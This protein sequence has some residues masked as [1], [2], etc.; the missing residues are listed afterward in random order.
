[1]IV[2][3]LAEKIALE[4]VARDGT[5][6]VLQLH[7]LA[8]RAY[9]DGHI[10]AAG[11]LL[12][13]ADAADRALTSAAYIHTHIYPEAPVFTPD[14]RRFVY[15]RFRSVDQPREYW[16]CDLGAAEMGA[17]GLRPLTTPEEEPSVHG[18][19]V[20]PDGQWFVYVAVPEPAERET[21]S[22]MPVSLKVL[23]TS[24]QTGVTVAVR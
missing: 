14:S 21:G 5:S 20:T 9:R 3:T 6:A 17:H 12:E 11:V 2:P 8:T 18:P 1:M 23:N 4:L 15:S 19:V 24:S 10:R 22:A 16:I 13:I 7:V